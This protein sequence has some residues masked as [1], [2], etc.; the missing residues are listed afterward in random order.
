MLMS[1]A[2]PRQLS[3]DD[4]FDMARTLSDEAAGYLQEAQYQTGVARYSFPRWTAGL[5]QL[6]FFHTTIGRLRAILVQLRLRLLQQQALLD[7]AESEQRHAA[8]PREESAERGYRLMKLEFDS[9]LR[10]ADRLQACFVLLEQ[11]G[12]LIAG[13]MSGIAVL[14]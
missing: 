4:L 7:F 2:F 13:R 1:R 5:R 9:R 12:K 11:G 10:E 8:E 14:A 3:L 6:G